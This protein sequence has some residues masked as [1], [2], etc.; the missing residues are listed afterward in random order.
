MTF[1]ISQ[2]VQKRPRR[3][4]KLRIQIERDNKF[5]FEGAPHYEVGMSPASLRDHNR[6]II[7][8]LGKIA[9]ESKKSIVIDKA[10]Y[11]DTLKELRNIGLSAYKRL[12]KDFQKLWEEQ[13]ENIKA[14]DIDVSFE[15]SSFPILWECLYS[16]D[17]TFLEPQRFWGC[18]HSITRI[19]VG[20]PPKP[21]HDL[22]NPEKFLFCKYGE[23]AHSQA[24]ENALHE[25]NSRRGVNFAILDEYLLK[26]QMKDLI[27]AIVYTGSADQFDFVHFVC[28]V[29]TPDNDRDNILDSCLLLS[30]Q[31]EEIR[32]PLSR[33][34]CLVGPANYLKSPLIFINACKSMVNPEHL[35]QGEGFPQ[36]FLDLGASAVIAT[37]CDIPDVFAKEF[38]EKFYENLYE[39]EN[40]RS[41]TL[42]KALQLTRQYFMDEPFFNP[43]GLA[44][45]LYAYYDL[46][47][48]WD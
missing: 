39:I 24:E 16:G 27:D 35:S 47:I 41:P 33:I 11:L 13:T 40:G 42:S 2:A 46:C 10:V 15:T 37:A 18:S 21:V 14:R 25:I 30:Y 4:H 17:P 28:H 48:Y 1:Q 31:S 6:A 19:F 26:S 29:I 8:I 23:L 20:Y 36:S 34:N 7:R 38:A 5:K 43:L 32:I 44:Y 3:S 9:A 12:G 45:G 22:E